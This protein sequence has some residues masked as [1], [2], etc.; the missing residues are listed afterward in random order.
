MKLEEVFSRLERTF[1]EA[2]LCQPSILLFDD[3]ELLLPSNPKDANRNWQEVV[4]H[5][6]VLDEFCTWLEKLRQEKHNVALMCTCKDESGLDAKLLH[7]YYFSLKVQC[8]APNQQDRAV[9]VE[10]IFNQ[11]SIPHTTDVM[12]I[13]VKTEGYLGADMEQLLERAIHGAS[14]RLIEQEMA[15]N[16]KKVNAQTLDSRGTDSEDDDEELKLPSVTT[17]DVLKAQEKFVPVSLKGVKLHQTDVL[18]SD[19]GGLESVKSMLKQ[20]LEWPSK[21][22]FLYKSTPIRPRSG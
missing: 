8:T 9:L 13:A 1:R 15:N 17:Q 6:V 4:Y 16:T 7:P 22:S 12:T 20:T 3:L 11:K 14:V 10:K 18:W 2:I 5:R 21:Y 19:I